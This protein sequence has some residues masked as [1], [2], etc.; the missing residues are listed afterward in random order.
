MK[1]SGCEISAEHNCGI[2]FTVLTIRLVL[3]EQQIH[4][5][6]SEDVF[7]SHSDS[8]TWGVLQGGGRAAVI[9]ATMLL[10]KYYVQHVRAFSPREAWCLMGEKETECIVTPCSEPKGG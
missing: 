6:E 1:S 8:S 10:G 9:E 3:Q 4:S 2:V 7:S 5:H